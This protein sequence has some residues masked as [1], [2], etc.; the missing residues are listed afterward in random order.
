MKTIFESKT[1]CVHEHP[2][3]YVTLTDFEPGK[4]L[5]QI[6]SDWGTYS[7]FWGSIGNDRKI[8]QFILSCNAGYIEN[9]LAHQIAATRLKKDGYGR[10]TKF[11]ALCWPRICDEILK[12]MENEK[13][14]TH[15]N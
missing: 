7:C 4:G 12:E 3:A 6:H 10:L 11:M 14:K 5:V 8:A 1:Y 15:S 13:T 9:N 2:F